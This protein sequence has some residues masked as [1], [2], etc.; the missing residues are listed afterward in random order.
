MKKCGEAGVVANV[1]ASVFSCM[2]LLSAAAGCAFLL[3]AIWEDVRT[4]PAA[5]TRSAVAE[6]CRESFPCKNH[7]VAV[8]G[9]ASRAAGRRICNNRVLLRNG[10]I[11]FVRCRVGDVAG[12]AAREV[13]FSRFLSEMG[14]PFIHVQAPMG[15]DLERTLAPSV[16]DCNANEKAEEFV[17]LLRSGGVDV[18]DLVP[19]FAATADDVSRNFLRTDHHWNYD[20]AFEASELLAERLMERLKLPVDDS[21]DVLCRGE[22]TRKER[23]RWRSGSHSY[24][25]GPLFA[26]V[27]D[28]SWRVMPSGKSFS[29]VIYD[30]EGRVR[31]TH[32]GFERAFENRKVVRCRDWFSRGAYNVFPRVNSLGVFENRSA[33]A[34]KTVLLLGDSFARPV[35]AYLSKIFRRIVIVDPRHFRECA[36]FKEMSLSELVRETMPDAVVQFMNSTSLE[37]DLGDSG[38][39]RGEVVDRMFAYGLP[40]EEVR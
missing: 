9:F 3:L 12:K 36:A 13:A 16:C 37:A 6:L 14:I 35:P 2:F 29:R 27:D 38:F 22:W 28:L 17:A 19:R 1:P 26:G 31:R 8:G 34:D 39:G 30:K 18:I 24:R 15:L 11:G 40:N 4:V 21:G 20:A 23:K 25:T 10:H 32:G 7:F 33:P 5:C